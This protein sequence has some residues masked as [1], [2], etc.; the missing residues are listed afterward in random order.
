MGTTRGESWSR[1]GLKLLFLRTDSQPQGPTQHRAG[2]PRNQPGGP[3]GIPAVPIHW[4]YHGPTPWPHHIFTS[5]PADHQA[6]QKPLAYEPYWCQDRSRGFDPIRNYLYCYMAAPDKR[7]VAR[8]ASSLLV[9][10]KRRSRANA[11][12]HLPG[13]RLKDCYRRARGNCR[14]ILPGQ[15]VRRFRSNRPTIGMASSEKAAGSGSGVPPL[16]RVVVW[17]PPVV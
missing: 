1:H 4:A 2:E 6:R 15:T 8:Q 9:A 12:L 17:T 10:C 7:Q 11:Q 14:R 13:P 5:T 16:I 3:D